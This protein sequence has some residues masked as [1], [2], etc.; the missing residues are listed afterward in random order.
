M[1]HGNYYLIFILSIKS[2]GPTYFQ[3]NNI[4]DGTIKTVRKTSISLV[5]F[6][7]KQLAVQLLREN[8]PKSVLWGH[9]QFHRK[10]TLT[11]Y[12]FNS[13]ST[14]RKKRVKTVTLNTHS[15]YIELSYLIDVENQLL[16]KYHNFSDF[17]KFLKSNNLIL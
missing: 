7:E 6:A 17:P 15:E 12:V 3:V 2:L 14:S 9:N 10:Q 11:K 16:V 5:T 1:G 13:T 4:S 8:F